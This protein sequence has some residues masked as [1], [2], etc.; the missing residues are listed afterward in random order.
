MIDRCSTTLVATSI[1]LCEI[2]RVPLAQ[3]LQTRKTRPVIDKDDEQLMA[4][5]ASGNVDAFKV[6][7]NRYEAS[8]YRFVYNGCNNEA[9][10]R[11]LFQDIWLRVVKARGTFNPQAPFKA[12]LFTI[13]RNRLTDN[14]RQQ[15][16][17]TSVN[18]SDRNT[19]TT[20][21]ESSQTDDKSHDE[22][23]WTTTLTPEQIAS[24]SQQCETLQNAL[25]RLPVA[26]REA[27]MLKHIA[28]MNI[29]EIAELQGEVNETVKSRLRYA[30]IK[31]R[32]YLKE[33]S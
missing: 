9:D 15:A 18:K 11:E 25:H 6:L 24:A 1:K 10:A 3:A 20:S 13:A 14:Y 29:N 2:E 28:G 19:Q 17:R 5:Y 23:W 12:W 16:N 31:L 30:M 7:Y 22:S 26:Q 21:N 4:S 32:Q 33:M 8:V 27:V